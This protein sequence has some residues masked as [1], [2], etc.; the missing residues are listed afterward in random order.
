MGKGVIAPRIPDL[1]TTGGEW[2]ASYTSRFSPGQE[3]SPY[4]LSRRLAGPRTAQD[5]SGEEKISFDWDSNHE[6][7]SLY[8]SRDTD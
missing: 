3:A 1:G 6:L 5:V 2:S 8:R 4:S 7:S